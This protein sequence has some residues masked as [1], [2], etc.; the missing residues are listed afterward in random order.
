MVGSNIPGSFFMALFEGFP[1][2]INF[3][4]SFGKLN[5]YEAVNMIHSG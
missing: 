4:P 3:L 5:Y 1:E 2:S